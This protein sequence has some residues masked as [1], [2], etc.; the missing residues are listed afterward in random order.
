MIS[1]SRLLYSPFL[2]RL[3]PGPIFFVSARVIDDGPLDLE[4]DQWGCVARWGRSGLLNLCGHGHHVSDWGQ[5]GGGR[6]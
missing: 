6:N 5:F 2:Q 4:A 1:P 3:R